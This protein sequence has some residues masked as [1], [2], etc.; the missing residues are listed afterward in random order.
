MDDLEVVWLCT[1]ALYLEPNKGGVGGL[2]EC[3]EVQL[4][5]LPCGFGS[6]SS[7]D[8]LGRETTRER[9]FVSGARRCLEWI[10]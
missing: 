9:A 3:E 5:V 8:Y 4:G 7:R 10:N 2:I 1:G 6:C